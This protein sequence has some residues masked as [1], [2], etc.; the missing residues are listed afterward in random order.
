MADGPGD[1]APSPVGPLPV[2]ALGGEGEAPV[3]DVLKR[4][5]SEGSTANGAHGG[6]AAG[7]PLRAARS[8]GAGGTA[9][10]SGHPF[11]CCDCSALCGFDEIIM[12]GQHTTH[13]YIYAVEQAKI[14]REDIAKQ[15]E[16]VRAALPDFTFKLKEVMD[17]MNEFEASIAEQED[18]VHR[19]FD[20]LYKALDRKKQQ[21]LDELAR[22]RQEKMDKYED[23]VGQM[24]LSIERADQALSQLTQLTKDIENTLPQGLC[25]PVMRAIVERR[26]LVAESESASTKVSSLF[27]RVKAGRGSVHYQPK[28][29]H[30]SQPP[31]GTPL[32]QWYVVAG[33][34]LQQAL[35]MIT[36]DA[37]YCP[38]TEVVE[39]FFNKTAKME[40]DRFARIKKHIT[41][42]QTSSKSMYGG[43]H[44]PYKAKQG[45]EQGR[46]LIWYIVTNNGEL[47]FT[48]PYTNG[49]I[50]VKCST[51]FDVG[52]CGTV[53]DRKHCT[54]LT[55]H[56]KG[57]SITITIDSKMQFTPTHFTVQHGGDTDSHA[58]RS[59]V[60]E[61]ATKGDLPTDAPTFTPIYSVTNHPELGAKAY[62]V[63]PFN[64]SPPVHKTYNAFRLRMTGKNANPD[65]NEWH[66]LCLGGIE[67]FGVL[68]TQ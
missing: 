50:K 21:A 27:G 16:G 29:K 9:L 30:R 37:S 36:S 28:A 58:L 11:Y 38:P 34:A 57:A 47:P 41:G 63:T 44:I 6:A 23:V 17:K 65:S 59:F 56:Q 46:G 13:E 19:N 61:A 51:S 25:S 49:M 43:T 53:V 3:P 42:F 33:Q 12:N 15:E 45:N 67:F 64:I 66:K 32:M 35:G 7:A 60:L 68:Y 39:V 14:V 52:D 48:N 4:K 20:T 54:C 24:K 1:A 5:G 26:N 31:L 22:I 18:S 10:S 55:K 8:S 40:I 62:Q 2:T